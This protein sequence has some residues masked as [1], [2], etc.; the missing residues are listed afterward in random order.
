M[1]SQIWAKLSLPTKSGVYKFISKDGE[2]LYIGKATNLKDRTKSYFAKDLINTRGPIIVKMVEDAETIEWQETDSVLEAIILEV[3][4]I[5]KYNP[6]YNTKEKDNKSY[7][8]V[9]ITKPAPGE[10]PRVITVRGRLIDFKNLTTGKQKLKSVYGPYP[11][12]EL[13]RSA[14]KIIRKIF[15][16]LDAKTLKKDSYEFYKQLQLA[17][18]IGINNAREKYLNNIKN[19]E[20][21]FK[22]EKTKI[23]KSLEKE[24][25]FSAKKMDFENA[26]NF[27]KQ[28][29]ALTHINEVSLLKSDFSDVTFVKNSSSNFRIEAYDI[30][31]LSGSDMVGAF[32]VVTDGIKDTDE[33]RLFNIRG[34]D[35]SNDAG[36][37]GELIERRLNH[38]E[39]PMPDIFVADG[40][41]VQKNVI[42]NALKKHRLNISVVAVVKDKSHRARAILGD[43][44]LINKNKKA[45]ILA[46]AEVHRFVLSKHKQKRAKS[47]L[48]KN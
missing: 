10:F 31:H 12:G 20:L 42:E 26:N 22:G 18:D 33:Y 1:K 43:V 7:N 19:I 34:F 38:K 36:A 32:S 3:N 40:N 37:L 11:S 46:N 29:F 35:S 39:W 28:I 6:K 8:Y 25:N 4:L 30:A 45:I 2:I 41:D 9:C 5:K 47:F 44:D 15:P 27:K 16:F 14:L 21:F 24:M 13:L 23:L 48:P 17:P